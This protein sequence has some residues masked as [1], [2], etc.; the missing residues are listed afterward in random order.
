MKTNRFFGI[1]A[2]AAMLASSVACEKEPET[3]PKPTPEEK[4]E[5]ST[6]AKLTALTLTAVMLLSRDS[7]TRLIK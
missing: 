2:V 3:T 4:P 5:L 6:E 1:L 7:F